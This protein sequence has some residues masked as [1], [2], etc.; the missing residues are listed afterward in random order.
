MV[1]IHDIVLET[2]RLCRYI[3]I[4]LCPLKPTVVGPCSPNAPVLESVYTSSARILPSLLAPI[5]TVTSISWRGED[6]IR[7]SFLV[8]IIFAGLPVF[9][10][11]IAG[12]TSATTVCLA[13]KPPPIRGLITRTLDFG[14]SK[15]FA[16]IL[17]TW[18]GI[19]VEEKTLIRP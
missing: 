5:V 8:K 14:M 6:A 4:D 16:M 17:R 18:N 15:A 12:Y 3:G 1:G 19:W 2:E 7:D 10:V 9:I 11:T 13:P